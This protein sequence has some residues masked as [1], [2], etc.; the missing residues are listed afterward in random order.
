MHFT[1]LNLFVIFGQDAFLYGYQEKGFCLFKG[2]YKLNKT[3]K[4]LES[5]MWEAVTF[6]YLSIFFLYLREKKLIKFVVK[7]NIR[8]NAFKG[9][10][11]HKGIHI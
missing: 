10:L 4:N 7:E 3:D 8:K 5:C 9:D 6:S 2:E 11:L 1:F